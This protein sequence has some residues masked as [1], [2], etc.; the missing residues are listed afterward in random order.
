MH[1]SRVLLPFGGPSGIYL[2][3]MKLYKSPPCLLFPTLAL[4]AGGVVGYFATI[5]MGIATGSYLL[6]VGGLIYKK[7]RERHSRFMLTAISLDLLLVVILQIQ[8]QAIQ[9]M[10]AFSL[11]GMQ[12]AH[13]GVSFAA[14]VLY[15]PVLYLG[16]RLW[17]HPELA[18]KLRKAHVNIA[19]TA[20]LLRTAGFIL[21]FSLLKKYVAA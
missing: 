6:L 4:L 9:T 19:I 8:R 2:P 14:T 17:K 10:L 1:S 7:N 20:F 11:T 3:S 15:F 13:V 12:Q 21:M 18:I 16:I 5:Y